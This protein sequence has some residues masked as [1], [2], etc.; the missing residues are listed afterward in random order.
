M[1]NGTNIE[2]FN[3]ASCVPL[4]YTEYP[5]TQQ[6]SGELYLS[7]PSVIQKPKVKAP[8]EPK[9]YTGTS[10]GCYCKLLNKTDCNMSEK[11]Q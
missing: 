10:E 11:S 9:P 7:F 6:P 5:F 2:T 1:G 4:Y 3:S 8:N